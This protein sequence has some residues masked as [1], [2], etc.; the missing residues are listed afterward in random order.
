MAVEWLKT[1]LL[2]P[3]TV[4]VLCC[5]A[6]PAGSAT[7]TVPPLITVGPLTELATLSVDHARV[8]ETFAVVTDGPAKLVVPP[9]NAAAAIVFVLFS[10]TRPPAT[11]IEVDPADALAPTVM[12]LLR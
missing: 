12:P 1:R 5:K 10:A 8:P 2:L 4:T 7:R 9:E 3:L 6:K 11:V